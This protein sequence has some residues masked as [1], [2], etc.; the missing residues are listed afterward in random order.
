MLELLS[1]RPLSTT[2]CPIVP[3][4]FVGDEGLALNRNKLRPLRG[5]NLRA[6]KE[7]TTTACAEH[8]GFGILSN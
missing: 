6:K 8:K 3:H 4:F 1:E 5:A 7:C 2:E